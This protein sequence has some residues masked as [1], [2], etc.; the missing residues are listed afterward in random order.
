MTGELSSGK[1]AL[2]P[3]P[4]VN[5]GKGLGSWQKR[6]TMSS[7]KHEQWTGVYERWENKNNSA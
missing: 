5:D 2:D 7:W 3:E 1:K 4:L 6:G